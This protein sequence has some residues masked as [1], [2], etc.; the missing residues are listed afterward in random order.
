MLEF[1]MFF[2]SKHLLLLAKKYILLATI[3]AALIRSLDD[4]LQ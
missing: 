4:E 1:L 3:S 2:N